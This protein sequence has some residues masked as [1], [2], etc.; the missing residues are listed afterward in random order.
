MDAVTQV[1]APIN[2]P[3][4]DYAPD[5]PERARLEVA[6]AELASEQVE[7]P[8]TIGGKRVMGGGRAVAVRQPHAHRSVLGTLKNATVADA[9]AAVDRAQ[10]VLNVMAE[11]GVISAAELQ[12]IEGLTPEELCAKVADAY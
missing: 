11:N 6:L 1:P 12:A 10:V 7:L 5:S 8:H 3:V 2:E 4:L 9:Q